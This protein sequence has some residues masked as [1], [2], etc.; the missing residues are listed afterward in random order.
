MRARWPEWSTTWLDRNQAPCWGEFG[1]GEMIMVLLTGFIWKTFAGLSAT[2]VWTGA[3]RCCRIQIGQAT[4]AAAKAA[5]VAAMAGTGRRGRTPGRTP[6]AKGAAG[7]ATGGVAR[8]PNSRAP[9][10]GAR[11]ARAGARG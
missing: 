3:M 4:W 10:R 11:V 9:G 1:N 7:E 5:R 8:P 2:T 6:G